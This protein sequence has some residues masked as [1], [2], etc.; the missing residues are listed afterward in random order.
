MDVDALGAQLGAWREG[1]WSSTMPLYPTRG[2]WLPYSGHDKEKTSFPPTSA[3]LSGGCGFKPRDLQKL[4]QHKIQLLASMDDI[5]V[6][7]DFPIS[8]FLIQLARCY[9][10]PIFFLLNLQANCWHLNEHILTFLFLSFCSIQVLISPVWIISQLE[11]A[12]WVPKFPTNSIHNYS[13]SSALV[14][15]WSLGVLGK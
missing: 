6:H 7:A 15:L 3:H 14:V 9:L 5:H 8:F 12:L 10:E 1:I 13:V 2:Q 11:C 4:F